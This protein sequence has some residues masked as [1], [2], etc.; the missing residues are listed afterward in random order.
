MT[1]KAWISVCFDASF[2]PISETAVFSP[3]VDGSKTILILH[4]RRFAPMLHTK[5]SFGYGPLPVTV[6]SEG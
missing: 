4:L 1:Y 5:V 3:N 2:H 6:E